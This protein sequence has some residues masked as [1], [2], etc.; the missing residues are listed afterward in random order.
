MKP[1]LPSATVLLCVFNGA[2]TLDRCLYSLQQQTTQD[3]CIVCIDDASTDESTDFLRQWQEKFGTER[4]FLYEN[5][6]N[7]GL[8]RSLNFGLSHIKTTFTARID[9]DDWWHPEKLEKQLA[10]LKINPPCGVVG[11]WYE[12][13]GHRGIRKIPLPE[14]DTAI[15][16]SILRQNPFAHSAVVFQTELIRAHGGYNNQWKY[17]QD[18]ELW[19]RLLS[20]TKF[21]NIPEYLCYRSADDT[22]TAKK[23]REQMFS[24]VKTQLLYLKQYHRPLWEY[25]FILNPLLVALAPEWL[26]QLKRRFL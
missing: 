13:H 12:N 7:L 25:C 20:Y 19:L 15:K 10:Y 18:Y 4:F 2:K 16:A 22:L 23:Q 3:F 14:T 8:T 5:K 26:R 24:C 1:T 9:A 21:A 17:G 11:T 6:V